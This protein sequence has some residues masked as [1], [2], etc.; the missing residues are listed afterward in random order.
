MHRRRFSTSVGLLM[1]LEKA[2]ALRLVVGTGRDY[3]PDKPIYPTSPSSNTAPCRS[4]H[5]DPNQQHTK[6]AQNQTAHP[7]NPRTATHTRNRPLLQETVRTPTRHRIALQHLQATTQL[8]PAPHPRQTQSHV[9]LA[10]PR[11]IPNQ[12]SPGRPPQTNRKR[13]QPLVR[14]PLPQRQN[15]THRKSRPNTP[16]LP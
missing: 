1:P 13:H 11:P 14:Q 7:T 5:Q 15:R 12:H 2:I 9:Q 10:R 4:H 6:W 3:I 16:S 8:R